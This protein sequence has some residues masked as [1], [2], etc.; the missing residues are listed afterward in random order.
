M[1]N[2]QEVLKRKNSTYK[3]H[4]KYFMYFLIYC[5]VFSSVY[6]RT[7][8]HIVVFELRQTYT[9]SHLLDV[10]SENTIIPRDSQLTKRFTHLYAGINAA[11]R[12]DESSVDVAAAAASLGFP[13]K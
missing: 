3:V 2:A 4:K 12:C 7:H 11:T 13:T 9:I 6:I 10:A 5:Y 8:V 1:E